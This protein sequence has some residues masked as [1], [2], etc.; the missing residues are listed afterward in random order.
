MGGQTWIRV[1][2]YKR[3]TFD[4]KL[5]DPQNPLRLNQPA[6]VK[7]EARYYFGLPVTS[8]KVRWRVD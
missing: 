7:G 4:A 8:G 3:P 2:E 5:L 1:E 6:S